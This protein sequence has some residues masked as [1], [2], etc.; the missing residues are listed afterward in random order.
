MTSLQICLKA[1]FNISVNFI[2]LIKIIPCTSRNLWGFRKQCYKEKIKPR[3]GGRG[4]WEVTA[5]GHGIS[6]WSDGKVLK[7]ATMVGQLHEYI[8]NH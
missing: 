8:K 4:E 5:N 7:L 3:P 6:F 1:L 2:H